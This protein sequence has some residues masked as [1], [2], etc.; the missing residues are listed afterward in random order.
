MERRHNLKPEY[1]L[2]NEQDKDNKIV[3]FLKACSQLCAPLGS[4]A[5]SI[6]ADRFGISRF[7]LFLQMAEFKAREGQQNG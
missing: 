6:A 2:F 7:E 1:S 4:E 3:H 5:L